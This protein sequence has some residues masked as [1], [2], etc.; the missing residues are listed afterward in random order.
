M[1]I[2]TNLSWLCSN[3]SV[4]GPFVFFYCCSKMKGTYKPAGKG[5][6]NFIQF[7]GRLKIVN[8]KGFI[9]KKLPDTRTRFSH[10]LW[11][12][13]CLSMCFLQW[14]HCKCPLILKLHFVAFKFSRWNGITLGSGGEQTHTRTYGKF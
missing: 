3:L 10:R 11:E 1:W 5:E 2:S 13:D 7:L 12:L 4:I 9:K 6:T 8:I 14:M